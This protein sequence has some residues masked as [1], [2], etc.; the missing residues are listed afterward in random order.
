MPFGVSKDFLDLTRKHQRDALVSLGW[1]IAAGLAGGIVAELLDPTR[2]GSFVLVYGIAAGAGLILGGLGGWLEVRSWAASLRDGW[3]DW[4][5]SA[6][7]AGS[8]GEAADRAGARRITLSG[9]LAAVLV[10]LNATVLVAAWFRLPPFELLDPYGALAL[11]TVS[12]TGAAVGA[13]AALGVVEAWWCHEIEDQ[14]LSL[15]E[16]GRVGVWGYR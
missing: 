5:H 11:V 4:M 15:V 1:L 16:S 10:V 14:T 13:R 9:V 12:S 7:G 8:I 2:L 6:V 3:Q